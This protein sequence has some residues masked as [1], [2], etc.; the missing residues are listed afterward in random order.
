MIKREIAETILGW[1][2]LLRSMSAVSSEVLYVRCSL[3][4][5]AQTEHIGTNVKVALIENRLELF[6][7]Q[8]R[9]FPSSFDG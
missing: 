2:L 4:W 6:E 8:F 7:I 9:F 3:S 5:A 1:N